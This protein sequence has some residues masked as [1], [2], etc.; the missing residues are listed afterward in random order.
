MASYRIAAPH[1]RFQE[2][3]SFFAVGPK[4]IGRML[5]IDEVD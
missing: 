3:L 4:P 1:A 5:D 2:H